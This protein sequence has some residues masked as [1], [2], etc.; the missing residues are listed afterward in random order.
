MQ[1][2]LEISGGWLS[3][4]YSASLLLS[5]SL[6]TGRTL[7]REGTRRHGVHLTLTRLPR[8]L[9]GKAKKT[10]VVIVLSVKCRFLV[11]GKPLWNS[12]SQF[13]VAWNTW[14]HTLCS[15]AAV[16]IS[17]VPFCSF[18]NPSVKFPYTITLPTQTVLPQRASGS[19]L[20]LFPL[21]LSS[22]PLF[23]SYHVAISI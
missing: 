5:K 8:M 14:G 2:I 19:P 13:P 12:S 7:T 10:R 16:S 3:L 17:S 4:I 6:H 1:A 22:F 11:K 21:D 15:S 20:R 9:R 23:R 18:F